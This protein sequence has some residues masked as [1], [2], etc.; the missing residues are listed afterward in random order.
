MK[1]RPKR[2]GETE[3][4]P[5]NRRLCK[6]RQ[7]QKNYV[8]KIPKTGAERTRIYREKRKKDENFQI[9]EYQ[10][11]ERE[12]MR[13]L[14]KVQ[15]K[16]RDYNFELRNKYR[17]KEKLRKRKQRAKHKEKETEKIRKLRKV[18]N[19]ERDTVD[20]LKEYRTKERLTKR[21]QR[22]K[23]KAKETESMRLSRAIM[24]KKLEEDRRCSSTENL[25]KRIKSLEFKIKVFQNS[26]RRL[27]QILDSRNTRTQR[28][29]FQSN[30]ENM[31]PSTSLLESVSTA[32]KKKE[33]EG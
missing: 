5:N 17:M 28:V 13:K 15:K 32:W 3:T 6:R 9:E 24:N 26:N 16:E 29:G 10:K 30:I 12:R 22:A 19:N 31:S 2:K 33:R 27:N 1:L 25:M 11:V 18:Q 7:N 14:R 23:S 4:I 21:K 20:L 8:R